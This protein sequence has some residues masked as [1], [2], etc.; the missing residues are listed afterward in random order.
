VLMWQIG[1]P[2]F[3]NM[4]REWQTRPDASPVAWVASA[5]QVT[6]T[7]GTFGERERAYK[8]SLTKRLLA[9]QVNYL[10]ADRLNT[11][12][13][14]MDGEILRSATIQLIPRIFYPE[15]LVYIGDDN[16]LNEFLGA[17]HYDQVSNLPCFALT[18]FGL[19][20][21][22]IYGLIFGVGLRMCTVLLRALLRRQSIGAFILFSALASNVVLQ[23]EFDLTGFLVTVR[24]CFVL[25]AVF[26]V[27]SMFRSAPAYEQ[28][29]FAYAPQV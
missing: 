9:F 25:F 17:G 19:M 24:L 23:M 28:D 12:R 21:G 6:L 2:F 7:G 16:M 15:K 13:E 22:V 10:V 27:F 18:D 20:G 4:R 26:Y 29:E 8:E 3:T 11:G 1:F 5:W 14:P